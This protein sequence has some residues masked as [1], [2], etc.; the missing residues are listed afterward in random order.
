M[1]LV[2]LMTLMTFD[3]LFFWVI[4]LLASETDDHFLVILAFQGPKMRKSVFLSVV[5]GQ[6]SRSSS[7]QGH[8]ILCS[9]SAMNLS[10]HCQPID[11]HLLLSATTQTY[12]SKW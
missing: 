9:C 6:T 1:Y 12:S 5:Q 3:L 2:T 10:G 11:G 7:C 4:D 8:L